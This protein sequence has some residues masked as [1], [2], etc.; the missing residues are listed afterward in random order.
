MFVDIGLNTEG[1]V[2]G[3]VD[4]SKV[5]AYPSGLTKSTGPCPVA[6]SSSLWVC[7]N[8]QLTG[9]VDVQLTLF[10]IILF[11]YLGTCMLGNQCQLHFKKVLG[12][13]I[14]YWASDFRISTGPAGHHKKRFNKACPWCC[15]RGL[16]DVH[17][18]AMSPFVCI[19]VWM[20]IHM[21]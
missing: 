19:Q 8:A 10:P 21:Y 13:H 5:S 3:T 7:K 17:T 6:L 15:P 20:H 4:F 11:T 2:E 14:L 9:P 18:K 16:K 12:L 1:V